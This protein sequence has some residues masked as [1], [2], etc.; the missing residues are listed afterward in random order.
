MNI[1]GTIGANTSFSFSFNSDSEKD[2]QKTE[3]QADE[4]INQL[5]EMGFESSNI[6][7]AVISTKSVQVETL[8]KY[9]TF[10]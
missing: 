10:G 1:R 3:R 6:Q 4:I 5:L 9:L 7:E 2:R 8:L